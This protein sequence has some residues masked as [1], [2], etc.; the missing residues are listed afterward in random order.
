MKTLR[1]LYLKIWLWLNNVCPKH[2]PKKGISTGGGFHCIDC[3][4]GRIK[5]WALDKEEKFSE[6]QQLTKPS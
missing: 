4:I 2:G 5:R 6:Y 3:E 1:K